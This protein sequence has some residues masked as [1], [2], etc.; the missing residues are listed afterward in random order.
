M[1]NALI[2]GITGQDGTYLSELLLE[3]GYNVYG[4]SRHYNAHDRFDSIKGKIKFIGGDI[5]NPKDIAKALKESNP[6]EVYNLA[7]ESSMQRAEADPQLTFK[8]NAEAVKIILEEIRKYNKNIKFFQALSS[9]L[10][11]G[12]KTSPQNESTPFSPISNYAK[13]KESSYKTCKEYREKYHLFTVCGIIYPHESIRRTKDFVTKYIIEQAVKI[14]LKKDTIKITI[15]TPKAKRDW[16]YAKEYVKA[17][18]LMLQQKEPKDYVIGSGELH[19]I[20]E[21]CEEV[22]KA[23]KIR[24]WQKHVVLENNP[25]EENIQL[26]DINK[27][28]KELGW[29]P[30]LNFKELIETIVKEELEKQ[31]L[32]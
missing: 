7:G 25:P 32:Q 31:R 12:T 14:K 6:S 17:M 28:K 23:L 9:K 22:F 3:K 18:W 15:K 27:I 24:D 29:T 8:I 21:F 1:K 5:I 2:F 19:T 10:F 16:G 4:L 20:E 30:K 13:S 11:E 26:A